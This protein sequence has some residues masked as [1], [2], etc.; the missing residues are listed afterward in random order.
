MQGA[1]LTEH[2]TGTEPHRVRGSHQRGVFGNQ[3]RVVVS[4][5]IL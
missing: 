5:S 3:R 1:E 4:F 2:R